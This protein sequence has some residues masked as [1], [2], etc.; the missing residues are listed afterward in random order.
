MIIA[1]YSS[2]VKTITDKDSCGGLH[3]R[4][5]CY[6]HE[7]LITNYT[8]EAVYATGFNNGSVLI[9]PW[10]Q[11]LYGP[12][13]PLEIRWRCHPDLLNQR[14]YDQYNRETTPT[15]HTI[16]TI[17]YEDLKRE[18][19]FV[20]ELNAVLCFREHLNIVKH[21]HSKEAVQEGLYAVRDDINKAVDVAPFV[22]EANDPSGRIK[23]LFIE[24]NGIICATCVTSIS[25][26]PDYVKLNL[27]DREHSDS[28]YTRYHTTF[29]EL[30]KQEDSHIWTLGGFRLASDRVW[31][32]QVLEI[33]RNA[34]PKLI[35]V[36]VV[37]D[38]IKRAR[39][40][41]ED[42]IRQLNEDKK[43]TLRR[44]SV[45]QASYDSLLAGDYHEKA[46]QHALDKLEHDRLKLQQQREQAKSDRDVERAKRQREIITTIGVVAKTVAVVL[47]ISIGI[48]KALRLARA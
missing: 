8:G 22:L 11:P 28:E 29:T 2:T 9:K 47:P 46:A 21:P 31:F 10:P 27:R 38:L 3:H 41:D 17:P 23:D 36:G 16:M 25:A 32:E 35:E 45:V 40:E 1:E 14:T 5:G 18:P 30:F 13:K 4:H 6:Y 24:V 19:H 33:E 43:E 42:H 12:S 34:K 20:E 26:E 44:L 48:Y 37:S 15:R 7:F 39:E